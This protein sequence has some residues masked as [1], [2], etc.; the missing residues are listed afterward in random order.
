[1][2]KDQILAKLNT[3]NDN[4]IITLS[5]GRSIRISDI[6]EI[7]NGISY[8]NLID[9][10]NGVFSANEQVISL[11]KFLDYIDNNHNKLVSATL[12]YSDAKLVKSKN[13]IRNNGKWIYK[14]I[15]F[16]TPLRFTFVEINN[17]IYIVEPMEQINSLISFKSGVRAI[18]D[19]LGIN[20]HE[21]VWWSSLDASA[22]EHL[23]E[24]PVTILKISN[25][26][27]DSNKYLRLVSILFDIHQYIQLE[28]G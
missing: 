27:Q 2:N 1:M 15:M 25:L 3:I 4:T 5:D 9:Q 10:L 24:V 21:E 6:S 14:E 20:N 23:L 26:S 16:Q 12:H 18:S 19:T 13:P 22:R 7:R 28:I 11:G 8:N 17:Y